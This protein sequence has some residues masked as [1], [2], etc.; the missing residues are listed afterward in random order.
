[1]KR[2]WEALVAE[3][4]SALKSLVKRASRRANL[5]FETRFVERGDSSVGKSWGG[6]KAQVIEKAKVAHG[7]MEQ[8]LKAAK[9]MVKELKVAMEGWT[10]N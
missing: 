6:E 7:E 3:L 8:R 9:A 4:G 2:D 10:A 5:S 1:M